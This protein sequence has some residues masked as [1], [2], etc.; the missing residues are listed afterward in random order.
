MKSHIPSWLLK[1]SAIAAYSIIICVAW[2]LAVGKDLNWD[3]INYHYYLPFS[4]FNDRLTEDFFPA[5]TQSYLNPIGY[6]PLYVLD[7]LGIPSA[8]SFSILAAV[9]SLNIF[10]LYLI[11]KLL[12]KS[13]EKS[14]AIFATAIGLLTQPFWLEVGNSFIDILTAIPIMAAIYLLI[15]TTSENA[16]RR[17]AWAGLLLGI[18]AGLKPTNAIAAVPAV[19]LIGLIEP[20][21]RYKALALFII[22]G[23]AGLLIF[24]GFWALKLY[25]TFGSPVFPLYNGYFHAADFPSENL[26]GSRF[27]PTSISGLLLFPMRMALVQTWVYIENIAP[28]IRFVVGIPLLAILLLAAAI[29][30]FAP[31]LIPNPPTTRTQTF[32]LIYFVTTYYLWVGTS[33]N[34]RYGIPQ[35]LLIGPA[36]LIALQAISTKSLVRIAL[37]TI[38]LIQLFMLQNT[39]KTR[40]SPASWGRHL[41]DLEIP[42]QLTANPYLFLSTTGPSNSYLMPFLHQDSR[43]VNVRGQYLLTLKGPGG[44]KLS[45]LIENHKENTRSLSPLYLRGNIEE[46]I[47]K[48]TSLQQGMFSPYGLKIKQDECVVFSLQLSAKNRQLYVS[49]RLVSAPEA[50][51]QFRA[52]VDPID[53]IFDN[54][55]TMCPHLYS[56]K[57]TPTE[58]QANFWK[59]HYLNT[60]MDLIVEDD[61]I[62]TGRSLS[63]SLVSLGKL[64]QWADGK[65]PENAKHL[66]GINFDRTSLLTSFQNDQ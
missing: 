3:L 35:L 38:F 40:W 52:E 48:L 29:H 50:Y 31:K 61:N 2:T 6:I 24:G 11:G 20:Q 28:D 44:D 33:A 8:I 62:M 25:L 30:K 37:L 54:I 9:H 16:I 27:T 57:S 42:A 21:K 45:A 60:E 56:P 10:L 4:L 34:G 26:A 51:V 64:H 49:C 55:A 53:R 66:C 46:S 39:M 65:I 59:R 36:I 63:M 32:F 41:F 14:P 43:L 23:I 15:S 7:S 13:D 17:V 18:A 19:L 58:H 22:S 1:D 5:S 12:S 47:I